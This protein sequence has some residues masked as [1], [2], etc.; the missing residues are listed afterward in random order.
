MLVDCAEPS[1]AW[2]ELQRFQTVW[3]AEF[4]GWIETEN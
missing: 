2:R 4:G 3:A 1:L